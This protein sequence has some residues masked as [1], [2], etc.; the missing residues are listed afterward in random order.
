MDYQ[1]FV[2]TQFIPRVLAALNT[3]R[4]VLI[5]AGVP[6]N[7]V[8]VTEVD[9]ENLRYRITAIRGP[10]TLVCYFELTPVT[11]IDGQMALIITLYVEGNGTEIT[12]SYTVGVPQR[13][14]TDMQ[15][16]LDKLTSAELTMGEVT[17]KARAFL[18]V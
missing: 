1:E 9:A 4:D 3:M 12:H 7:R 15:S 18:Q 2:T 11:I 6:S 13:Y 17:V 5:A 14:I 10:R 8:T 16:I